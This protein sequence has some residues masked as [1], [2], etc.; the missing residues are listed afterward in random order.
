VEVTDIFVGQEKM[1]CGK[2]KVLQTF[3]ADGK[4]FWQN[5]QGILAK[6]TTTPFKAWNYFI[7][8]EI[9][10][11]IVQHTNQYVLIQP[12]FSLAS[13]SR[14][15]DKIELKAVV[16]LSCLAGVLRSNKQS[17]EKLKGTDGDDSE[18]NFA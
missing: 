6:Q 9:W 10:D 16:G 18:K 7:T 4:M 5:Y 2:D 14:L 3:D 17:L 12:H 13:D 11:N 15:T 1:K 8:D